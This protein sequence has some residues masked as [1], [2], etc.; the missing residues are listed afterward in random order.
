MTELEL[1]EKH[2][3]D[4]GAANWGEYKAALATNVV[5]DEIPLRLHVTGADEYVRVVQRWKKAFPDLAA[6]V[7]TVIGDR[8]T[9]AAQ[10][11]WT[12]TQTGPL[13]TPFGLIAPTNKRG[14]VKAMLMVRIRDGKIVETNHYF[15]V[16]TVLANLGVSPILNLPAK[17]AGSD[18]AAQR[19]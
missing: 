3:K 16:L 14:T 18:S 17:Q 2:L 8:G 6:K 13:E 11:E 9:Y 1:I 7:I 10:L 5:F 15:D 19:H 4:F 12:G